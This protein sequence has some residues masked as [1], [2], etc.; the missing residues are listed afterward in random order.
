MSC[1]LVEFF[2]VHKYNTT[3]T[4]SQILNFSAQILF[5]KSKIKKLTRSNFYSSCCSIFG[6]KHICAPVSDNVNLWTKFER[7]KIWMLTCA[8]KF[9]VCKIISHENTCFLLKHK[10]KSIGTSAQIFPTSH[11]FCFLRL[12]I[13]NPASTEICGAKLSVHSVYGAK[14]GADLRSTDPTANQRRG[15]FVPQP[16]RGEGDSAH[17]KLTAAETS[18]PAS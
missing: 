4:Q 14:A 10:H 12:Q 1:V 2:S 16:I 13:T 15:A 9:N 6:A 7:V 11:R 5:Y 18:S 17:A 3:L 8:I